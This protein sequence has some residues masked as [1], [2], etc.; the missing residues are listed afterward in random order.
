[1]SGAY[2]FIETKAANGDWET[3]NAGEDYP[4][5]FASLAEARVEAIDL[6]NVLSLPIQILKAEPIETLSVDEWLANH[7]TALAAAE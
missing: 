3:W 4:Q 5:E 1:M 2:Y 7:A 6:F